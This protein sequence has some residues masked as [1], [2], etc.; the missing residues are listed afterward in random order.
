MDKAPQL[1]GQLNSDG[2][3]NLREDTTYIT[4]TSPAPPR[5]LKAALEAVAVPRRNTNCSDTASETASEEDYDAM[6]HDPSAVVPGGKGGG[7]VAEK[8]EEKTTILDKTYEE[9]KRSPSRSRHGAP[10]L[11]SISV[12]LNKLEGEQGRYVLIADDDALREILKVGIERVRIFP[13]Q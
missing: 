9:L 11:K 13:S 8:D 10:R 4:P 5:S 12:T 3:A 7:F 6:K 1:V 2:I